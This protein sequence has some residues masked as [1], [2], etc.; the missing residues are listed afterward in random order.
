MQIRWIS[1]VVVV[2]PFHQLEELTMLWWRHVKQKAM[3]KILACDVEKYADSERRV[4]RS[5]LIPKSG[6]D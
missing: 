3:C 5:V 2:Q 4:D 1:M 6:I